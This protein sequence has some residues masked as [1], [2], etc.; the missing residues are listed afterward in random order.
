MKNFD[1]VRRR[2]FGSLM[3]NAIL[4][5]QS[6]RLRYLGKP[7][8]LPRIAVLID[9]DNANQLQ[10]RSV[11]EILSANWN[12][13]IQRAYGR[14]LADRAKVFRE[15]GITPVEVIPAVPK[16]NTTDFAIFVDAMKILYAGRVDALCLVSSDSDFCCLAITAR[17]MSVPVVVFAG[18]RRRRRC[19]MPVPSF[20]R[21]ALHRAGEWSR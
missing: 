5:F 14:G 10:I 17:E 9:S 18:H 19:G 13:T 1:S 12:A 7:F 11:F 8:S 4:R 6:F 21:S 20:T 16:K 2:G 3:R 15:L